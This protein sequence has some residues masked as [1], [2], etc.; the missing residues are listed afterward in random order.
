MRLR[1]SII[2]I[3][4]ISNEEEDLIYWFEIFEKKLI[5]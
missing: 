3:L 2:I 4:D 5:W 1:N